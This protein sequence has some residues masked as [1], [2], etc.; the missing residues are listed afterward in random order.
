MISERGAIRA[1]KYG[2]LRS[3]CYSDEEVK[4]LRPEEI[5]RRIANWEQMKKLNADDP[6]TV[7]ACDRAISCYNERLHMLGVI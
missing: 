2:G 7:A 6:K 4:P 1:P 3:R 5:D